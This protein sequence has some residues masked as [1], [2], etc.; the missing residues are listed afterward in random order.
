[1]SLRQ[2][3]L[4]RQPK[5]SILGKRW[6]PTAE[7][8]LLR[9]LCVSNFWFYFQWGFGA[10]ANPKGQKWIDDSVHKSL[11]DWFQ[12]HVDEWIGWRRKGEVKQ[13]LLAIV[14]HR[15]VGKTTL[16]AQAG[17]S[18]LHLVDPELSTFTVSEKLET[19]NRIVGPIKAVMDGSDTYSLWTPLFGD[20]SQNSRTWKL[21]EIV[22]SARRNTARKD[23]SLGTAG[24]ETSV[25]GAHPD[26]IFRDDPISYERMESDSDWLQ[27][28]NDQTSSLIPVLQGDGMFVDIGTR[29]ASGD[30]L[31][32]A[33]TPPNEGGD[34]VASLSGIKTDAIQVHEDGLWH[35]YFMAA[36]DMEGN[37][38]TPR[39]WPE[40]RLHRYKRVDPIRYS[41]QIM[42]DPSDSEFNPITRAQLEQCLVA[43]KDVPWSSLVYAITTD[44]ALWDG[45]K[46]INKDETVFQV[47]GYPRNGS[48]DI[49]FIEGKSDMF[50]R[51]EDL[52]PLLVSTVQRY[53][54]QGRRVIGISGEQAGSGLKGIWRTSLTNRFHDKGEP[55]PMIHEFNRG[56]VKKIHRISAVV[57]RW[58][59]NHV[60]VVKPL[61]GDNGYT[62]LLGQMER[63]GEMQ[64]IS[65]QGKRSTRK[66]DWLDA[67]ADAF[68]PVFYQPMR[69]VLPQRPWG[70]GSTLLDTPGLSTEGWNDDDRQWMAENPRP[71]IR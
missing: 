12:M 14:V 36:K 48:G 26:V 49:Y 46:R 27:R 9:S 63:I 19:A 47:W 54:Q 28:V 45:Q 43:P 8:E 57:E 20:W 50:W 25:T 7:A 51:D 52:L 17:Q 1:M 4:K 71:P 41:S 56:S 23:P 22:H 15:E 10:R 29:Y 34:G 53:R 58:V 6:D 11:A 31:G 33:F 55:C 2:A 38:T 32:R 64:L 39:I 60:R 13:K 37:V 40:H 30:H 66:D 44:L 5:Q 67:M 61:N 68:E 35:V 16:I 18:W 21:N 24:V 42:N 69:R 62:R 3:S 65:A 59:D 70:P